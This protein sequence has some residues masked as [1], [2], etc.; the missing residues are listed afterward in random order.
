MEIVGKNPEVGSTIEIQG[1][2]FWCRVVAVYD[3]LPAVRPS[4]LHLVAGFDC[5]RGEHYILK[6]RY[7]VRLIDKGTY[8]NERS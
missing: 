3:T 4:H 1:F 8:P 6:E 5:R 2:P 7:L